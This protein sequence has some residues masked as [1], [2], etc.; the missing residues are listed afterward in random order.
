MNNKFLYQKIRNNFEIEK[1][2]FF[3]E[4]NKKEIAYEIT[5]KKDTIVFDLNYKLAPSEESSSAAPDSDGYYSRYA[6]ICLLKNGEI[7]DFG[8]NGISYDY[9]FINNTFYVKNFETK[10]YE[11]YVIKSSKSNCKVIDILLP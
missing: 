4:K 5:L 10:K 1:K 7:F 9:I 11:E 3:I 8:S 2:L 6:N